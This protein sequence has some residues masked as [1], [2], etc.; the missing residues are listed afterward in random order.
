MLTILDQRKQ[1]KMQWLQVPNQSN[2]YNLHNVWHEASRHLRTKKKKK[3]NV[4]AKIYEAESNN[5]IKKTENCIGASPTLRK[6]ISLE[7]I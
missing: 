7:L 2:L 6:V 3:E 1:A 4:R 5:K